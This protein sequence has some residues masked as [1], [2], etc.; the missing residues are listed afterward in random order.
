MH[1]HRILDLREA[2]RLNDLRHDSPIVRKW[3]S[4]EDL[5][6]IAKAVEK[7]NS[8]VKLEDGNWYNIR[9]K[10]KYEAVF[11]KPD[12]GFVPCGYLRYS[13]LKQVLAENE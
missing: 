6:T 2:N 13:K 8:R 10:S 4:I 12:R 7:R 3:P 1:D 11:V 9:Y 5:L